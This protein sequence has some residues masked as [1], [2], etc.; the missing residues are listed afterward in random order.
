MEKYFH[1]P[2]LVD[3][4]L[5]YL[6]TNLEGIYV[7]GTLGGGGHSEAILSNISSK[8]QL[9]CMDVDD[10]AL[11]FAQN[12]LRHFDERVNFVKA[13]FSNL[14]QVLNQKSILQIDG[15]LLDLGVSSFQID[16]SS[17]GFSFQSDALI[18]MRMNRRQELDGWKVVNQYDQSRLAEIFLKYSEERNSKRIARRIIE[19]RSRHSIDTTTDLSD[20]IESAVGK[21]FLKKSLARIFQAIRIEVNK[22]LDNLK[23]VLEDAIKFLVPGGRL[24][25]ISYHSLEDRIV[26]DFFR[27]KS[28][29]FI[30]SK[31]KLVKDEPIMPALKILTKKPLLASDD[32]ITRNPRARSAKMRVAERI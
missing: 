31:H 29:T 20:A 15:L 18:D 26:K 6:L 21:K 17:R 1:I 12:R 8:G 19:M 2:V 32:E 7:D 4:V 9:L 28:R 25:V 22:E 23:K 10:D 11:K 14:A 30:P 5:K 16:E 27:E 13:N 24:V 3:E